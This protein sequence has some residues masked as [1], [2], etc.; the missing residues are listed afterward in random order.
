MIKIFDIAQNDLAQFLRNR[1]TF[2]FFLVMPIAFTL[3]FGYAFGGFGGEEDTRLPVSLLD[4]D[5]ST[6]SQELQAMLGS[7]Q[8][9]RIQPLEE[10]D[11]QQA[12]DDLSSGDLA[13]I[14]IVPASFAAS[15]ESG[16]PEA[17]LLQA[18]PASTVITT[19]QGEATNAIFR[20]ANAAWAARVANQVASA[21]F[22]EAFQE[23]LAAWEAPP[24]QLAV[25]SGVKNEEMANTLIDS[26]AHSSPGMMI[27]FAIAGLL[28]AAQV[29][30][31]E[32]RSYS[33]QRLLTTPTRRWYI[34]V[35]H[36]LG[37]FILILIQ[38][39]IL[40]LFGQ[41]FL[42]V[43]YLS[44][45]LA[46]LLVMI[47]TAAC[48]SGLGL[49]IG[50]VAKSDEQA[51]I[52]SL[53]PMFVMAGLGGAWV[54]LEVTG[55]AF[56]AVGHVSPVAWAMDGFKNVTVRGLG[57]QAVLLPTLALLVYAGAFFGLA[58]WRFNKVEG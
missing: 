29:I 58:V 41:V 11:R 44:V 4:Q 37:I 49:L 52:F 39:T 25:V 27:Q 36:Y 57:L 19:I 8:V 2:L 46:T 12:E 33:L 10:A 18:S 20:L 50:V 40:I 14:L 32:R 22:Q 31:N 5:R 48:I 1:M 34:L 42:K 3:L 30:V 15:L 6:Y 47:G 35:G 38:F 45:P 56:Q 43:N 53:I 21:D 23:S 28:V 24:I 7:S 9:I 16:K 51:V 54:P 55:P 26:M 13:A 17:V